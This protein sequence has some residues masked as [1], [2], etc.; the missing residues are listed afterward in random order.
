MMRPMP[1]R[2][3]LATSTVVGLVVGAALVLGALGGADTTNP[4]LDPRLQAGLALAWWIPMQV[5]AVRRPLLP[6]WWLAA[7]AALGHAAASLAVSLGGGGPWPLWAASWLIL[8]ELP[9]LGAVVQLFPT[10]LTLPRWR[11]YLLASVSSG[12]LGIVAAALEQ[13]PGLDPAARDLAGVA[14]IPLLAFSVI[15]CLLPLAVRMVR[16]VGAERSAC[17]WLLAVVALGLAVPPL[18]AGGG[19]WTEVVA[20]VLTAAQLLLVTVAVLR[21]RVWGLAPMLRGSLHAVVVATDAERR[22]VRDELHDGL[23]GGLTA[24]RLK[25]DASRRMLADQPHRAGEVLASVSTD[26]GDLVEETRR[27]TEGLRPAALDRLGLS[28]ALHAHADDLEDHTPGLEVTVSSDGLP[29]LT[30]AVEDVVYRVV[31]EALHNVVRHARAQRCHVT[32]AAGSDELTVVVSDDG[33][34][35]GRR[36]DPRTGVGLSSMSTRAAAVG[37]Y[38]VAGQQAAGGFAVRAVVPRIAP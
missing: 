32:F 14:A 16:T 18:V 31:C 37:G 7:P 28:G 3:A 21:H 2:P 9:V 22:R 24:V 29:P 36:D 13:L 25:V 27:L 33:T 19:A 15:G 34:G 6:F 23:G 4:A 1:S 30:T 5:L 17:G 12:I 20:Q 10:G 11:G 38:V 35:G 8:V 26:L